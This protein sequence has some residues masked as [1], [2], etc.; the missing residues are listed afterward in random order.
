MSPSRLEPLES[1]TL[2]AADIHF[3]VLGDFGN[4][5][6]PAAGDVADLVKS[7]NPQFIVT[8]GDNNY[9]DGA[10]ST[11]DANI[12]QFFH[13]YIYNY[14]GSYGRGSDTQRFFP[15]LG[16]HDW[17][18]PNAKPYLDY[19]TLPGNERYYTFT[20]GPVQFF[21][22][23]SD[24]KEPDL[25]FVSG[26]TS[27]AS[28]PQGK[29]LKNALAA[30]TAQ[31]KIVYFHHAPY[32]SGNVHGS[33]PFMQWPFKEW[34]ADAVFAG[35]V[36]NYERVVRDGVPYFVNGSGGRDLVGF[37]TPVQGSKLRYNDDYGAMRVDA[38]GAAITFQFIT[39]AG[40]LI[41][42]YTLNAPTPAAPTKLTAQTISPS[43]IDL[44]WRDNAA[45]EAG[46]QLFRS[47]DGVTYRRIATLDDDVTRYSDTTVRAGV[48]YLYVLRA[49]N[50]SGR[51]PDSNTAA[52]TASGA[53]ALPGLWMPRTIGTGLPGSAAVVKGAYR[54]SGSGAGLGGTADAFHYVYQPMTTDARLTTRVDRLTADSPDA[55]AGL[56]IRHTLRPDSPSAALFVTQDG[57]VVF[58]YRTTPAGRTRSMRVTTPADPRY[59]QLRRTGQ[60]LTALVSTDGQSWTTVR[61]V[62][63]P[64]PDRYFAGLAVASGSSTQLA[65]A[66]L[67]QTTLTTSN[68]APAALASP[69]WSQQRIKRLWTD[70]VSPVYES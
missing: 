34:G 60:T 45:T 13:E 6:N 8:V 68:A 49:Y 28:S 43:R 40:E 51:S 42:T 25:D 5:T 7:W 59:L 69:L 64:M 4:A 19:F 46:F 24:N 32:S 44:T 29:W 63:I 48:K 18:T 17:R 55:A 47:T 11:I 38:S 23:D 22:I 50:N 16:N 3:A 52:A 66:R 20:Q 65:T 61:S 54:I 2:L 62:A 21:A 15:T 57:R 12:G 39:R 41:D 1:R 58:R 67:V 36:H 26:S 30:S 56:V 31:W 14:R 35:H 27:T 33:A 37:T 53:A 70:E 10:A 9:P